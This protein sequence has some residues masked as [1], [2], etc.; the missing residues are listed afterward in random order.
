ME[1]WLRNWADLRTFGP[2]SSIRPRC[3]ARSSWRATCPRAAVEA[4]GRRRGP[5]GDSVDGHREISVAESTAGRFGS[6]SWGAGVRAAPRAVAGARAVGRAH[7]G[8]SG[9]GIRPHGLDALDVLRLE[10]GHIFLGQDSLPD[11]HPGKL[12]LASRSTWTSRSSWAGSRWNGWRRFPRSAAWSPLVRRVRG[13]AD[14]RG[15]PL[16]VGDR[17]VGRVTSAECSP[18][19]GGDMGLGWIRAVD[20]DFATGCASGTPPRSCRRPSTIP[21]GSAFVLDAPTFEQAWCRS[22]CPPRPSI[23]GPSRA[24]VGRRQRRPGRGHAGRRSRRSED[25]RGGRRGRRATGWCWTRATDGPPGRSRE[26]KPR[27]FDRFSDLEPTDAGFVQGEVARVPVK[28]LVEPARITMLI[29]AMWGDYLD[30]R[31]R[32]ECAAVGRRTEVAS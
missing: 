4:H 20:G 13:E 26:P 5:G 22:S 14:L 31:I 17:V 10:K 12:G 32:T 28:E 1:A 7:G 30:E 23:S 19:V 11:D 8:G 21:K 18:D 3:S 6:G 9:S 25:R 15:A 24:I 16:A 29:G 27:G 2:T